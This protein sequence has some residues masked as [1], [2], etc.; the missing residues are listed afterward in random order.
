MKKSKSI[1][2]V[3]RAEKYQQKLIKSATFS[4]MVK[5]SVEAAHKKARKMERVKGK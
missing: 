5:A 1:R 4:D 3:I 2:R